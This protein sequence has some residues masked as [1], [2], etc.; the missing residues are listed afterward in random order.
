MALFGNPSYFLDRLPFCSA[1]RFYY[2]FDAIF[3]L[4]HGLFS[5]P[6]SMKRHAPLQGLLFFVYY[7]GEIMGWIASNYI[8]KEWL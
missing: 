3:N 1:S 2:N 7:Y 4:R 6:F 5:A 8:F